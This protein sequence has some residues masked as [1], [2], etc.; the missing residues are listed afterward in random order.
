MDVDQKTIRRAAAGDQGAY[1]MIY[2]SYFG[3]V[4]NVAWRVTG[5]PHDAEEVVQEVFWKVYQKLGSFQF[6][7]SLKTWI[8]RITV[9][10]AINFSKKK[11]RVQ[12]PWLEYKDSITAD[13]ME[14]NDHMERKE[15]EKLVADFLNTLN[16]EQRAC[17]VLRSTEGLSYQQIA[18]VLKIPINT[19]RS[20]IKRAREN[21]MALRKE[22]VKSEL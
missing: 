19:V 5:N 6:E 22:V 3:F 2:K 15:N 20:R 10:Q 11:S 12:S 17:L 14:V 4:S 18:D 13:V 8:Y 9:N 16:A 1:A 21:M 7:S